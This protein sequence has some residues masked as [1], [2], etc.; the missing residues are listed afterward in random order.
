MSEIEKQLQ[1]NLKKIMEA[2]LASWDITENSMNELKTK[3]EGLSSEQSDLQQLL[4]EISDTME[5]LAETKANNSKSLEEVIASSGSLGVEIRAERASICLLCKH[6]MIYKQNVSK[7]ARGYCSVDGG[8]RGLYSQ[9]SQ[10]NA[11][12]RPVHI[13]CSKFKG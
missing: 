9:S 2:S 7:T 12:D 3:L 8:E 5:V 6:A 1:Q 11:P 13:S 4:S 10:T